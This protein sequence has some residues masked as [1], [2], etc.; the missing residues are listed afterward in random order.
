MTNT[1]HDERKQSLKSFLEGQSAVWLI[2]VR[3]WEAG[4]GGGRRAGRARSGI[5]PKLSP[6]DYH[7]MRVSLLVLSKN[8][9][10]T[11]IRMISEPWLCIWGKRKKPLVW[12]KWS[13]RR[14]RNRAAKI[15]PLTAEW[16]VHCPVFNPILMESPSLHLRGSCGVGRRPRCS[17]WV[18]FTSVIHL[19]SVF[20][21]APLSWC[22]GRQ[23]GHADTD[24]WSLHS[25]S[26]LS[27]LWFK[28][29]NLSEPQFLHF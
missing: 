5:H 10:I 20:W 26:L 16:H 12:L 6:C 21:V 22:C 14:R 11:R 28:S 9:P 3:G 27:S 25:W 4:Q 23:H 8:V 7:L 18:T 19:A 13:L 29:F 1:K 15:C 24:V 2:G 17:H